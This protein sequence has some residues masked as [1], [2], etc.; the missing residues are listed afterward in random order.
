MLWLLGDCHNCR[1]TV[2]DFKD[3]GVHLGVIVTIRPLGV[4]CETAATSIES[5]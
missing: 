2:F 5:P 3:R 1:D 4:A